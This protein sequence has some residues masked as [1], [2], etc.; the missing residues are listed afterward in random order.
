MLPRTPQEPLMGPGRTQTPPPRHARPPTTPWRE[1]FWPPLGFSWRP[2]N[3]TGQKQSVSETLFSRRKTHMEKATAL[4]PPRTCQ[5]EL[6]LQR[7]HRSRLGAG[8]PKVIKT[9][10]KT[11]SSAHPWRPKTASKALRDHSQRQPKNL[12]RKNVLNGSRA[13]PHTLLWLP[14]STRTLLGVYI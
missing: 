6:P 9:S 8:I 12:R 10:P 5:I 3:I 1:P 11:T 13:L 14:S 4:R 7:E 2:Q